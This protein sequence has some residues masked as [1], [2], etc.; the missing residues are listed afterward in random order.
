[1]LVALIALAMSIILTRQATESLRRL[2]DAA[3][4]VAAGDLT[5]TVD[6][7]SHDEIGTLA[8]AFNAMTESLRRTLS[9]LAG[10][11]ALAAVGEFAATLSHEI[12][13]SLTAVRVDLQ[14]ARRHLPPEHAETKLVARALDSVRRL[15]TVVTGALRVA[16]G[17]QVARTRVDLDVIL[18]RAVR[19]AAPAFAERGAELEPP[20]GDRQL[21]V[22]GD[23][24]A[25]E[26]LF[27]NL[28]INAAQASPPGTTARIEVESAGS[29]AIVRVIDSGSG[30]DPTIRSTVGA[31]FVTTKA[32]GTG[33]GLPIARRIAESHGGRLTLEAE[34]SAG[35]AATVR[36]PLSVD[37]SSAQ[38]T[39]GRSRPTDST[40]VRSKSDV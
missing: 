21:T 20:R 16:R 11:R 18:E 28:L 22:D 29:C 24:G 15:D 14:H 37:G 17:G 2:A 40:A 26:Q 7:T 3:T 30:M 13:N 33:L 10:Q 8:R 12:R 27:L 36:L 39:H 38:T 5:R 9:D 1:M 25:L 19:S 35:T 6:A 31:P 34:A 4:A 32:D 23:S